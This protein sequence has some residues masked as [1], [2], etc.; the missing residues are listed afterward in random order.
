M[1]ILG[2]KKGLFTDPVVIIGDGLVIKKPPP[3]KNIKM[4]IDSLK[5][6]VTR[7]PPTTIITFSIT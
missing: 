1:V 2:D 3:N 7:P 6:T 4:L 5:N